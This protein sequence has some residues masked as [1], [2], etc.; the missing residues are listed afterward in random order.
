[1]AREDAPVSALFENGWGVL[2]TANYPKG[3]VGAVAQAAVSIGMPILGYSVIK[4]TN[5]QATAGVS[6][7]FGITWPHRF[8]KVNP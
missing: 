4:L 1:M 2:N 8:T 3:T 7:N 5:P 6:G